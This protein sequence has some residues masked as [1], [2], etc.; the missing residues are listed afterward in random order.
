MIHINKGDDPHEWVEE[1]PESFEI[2]KTV[3]D[4]LRTERIKK[5]IILRKMHK[6]TGLD[7]VTLSRIERGLITDPEMVKKFKEALK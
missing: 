1:L 3:D 7:I 2:E 5:R 6:R 4:T